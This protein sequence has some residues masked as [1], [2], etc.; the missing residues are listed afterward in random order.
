MVKEVLTVAKI[1]Q[2]ELQSRMELTWLVEP[3]TSPQWN[4][5]GA[6]NDN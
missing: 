1:V 6:R 5:V 2:R 4:L 3:A